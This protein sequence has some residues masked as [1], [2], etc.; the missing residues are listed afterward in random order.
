M[1]AQIE[2]TAKTNP[3]QLATGGTSPPGAAAVPPDGGAQ[4]FWS[5]VREALMGS[6][7]DLTR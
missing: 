1:D 5:L 7:R 6:R 3:D 2:S 4:G